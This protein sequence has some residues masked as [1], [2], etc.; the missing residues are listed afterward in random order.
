MRIHFN[1]TFFKKEVAFFF[2]VKNIN[3]LNYIL[4]CILKDL[5]LLV[6]RKPKVT[7]SCRVILLQ[8]LLIARHAKENGMSPLKK[9]GIEEKLVNSVHSK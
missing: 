7:F 4:D 6:F 5:V 9:K 2:D 1:V 8:R 3:N